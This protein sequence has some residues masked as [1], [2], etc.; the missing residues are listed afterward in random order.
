[1]QLRTRV[2]LPAALLFLLA[3]GGRSA[4][5][6]GSS[7]SG[8]SASTG[9]SGASASTASGGATNA[10]TIFASSYDHSCAI[11]S[12]CVGVPAGANFCDPCNDP[13]AG[14]AAYCPLAAVNAR[15]AAQYQSDL[16]AVLASLTQDQ[17]QCA[18]SDCPLSPVPVCVA[19]QCTVT[20]T[21]PCA[22]DLGSCR[23]TQCDQLGL[24]AGP[25]GE[26]ASTSQVCCLK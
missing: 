10:C 23:Y 20:S 4:E 17:L 24:D 1:M 26:C 15:V 11:D 22:G 12:D 8:P 2:A 9:S 25:A 14:G 6:P 13:V 18:A 21:P 3:C 19:G 16:G 7:G 5:P